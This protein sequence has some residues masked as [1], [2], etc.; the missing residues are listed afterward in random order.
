[1]TDVAVD[2]LLAS[3]GRLRALVRGRE[4]DPALV[5]AALLALLL[6]SALLYLVDLGASG[7]ANAYYAGAVQAAT[8]SWKAFLFGSFDSSNFITVDKPPA[9]MWVMDV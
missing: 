1:M 6:V 8:K 3:R 5:R 9:S 4:D 7:W 2:Q